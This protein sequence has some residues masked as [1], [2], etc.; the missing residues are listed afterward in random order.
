MDFIKPANIKNNLLIVALLFLITLPASFP[1]F[2]P[3]FFVTQD[4][5]YLPRIYQLDKVLKEGVF[6]VRW[7]P[8][9]RYG[10]PTFNFYAPLPYYFASLLKSIFWFFG[11]IEIIKVLIFLILL[12]SV[13]SMYYFAAEFFK[14]VYAGILASVLYLYAPYHSLD[15]YVRG[16]ISEAFALIFFPLMFLFSLRL[17]QNTNILNLVLLSLSLAGLFL[18]HNVMTLIF[19]PFYIAWIMFLFAISRN[20]KSLFLSLASIIWA[21]GLAAFFLLP[22]FLEKNFVQTEYLTG[23]YFDF[24][25]HFIELRQLFVLFWGYGASLW[26]GEDGLSFQIGLVHWLLASTAGFF[27]LLTFLRN[28]I[29]LK[30]FNSLKLSKEQNKSTS[31]LIFLGLL[32]LTSLFL[33]HNKTAFLWENIQLL[34]F[35]QFP[36]RFLGISIFLISIIGAGFTVYLSNLFSN[37]FQ[38]KGLFI[39]VMIVVFTVVFNTVFFNPQKIDPNTT[40]NDF[41]SQDA[42]LKEENLPKDYLPV[43]V[44]DMHIEKFYSPHLTDGH[45]QLS[46]YKNS[47]IISTLKVS[48]PSF[49]TIEMPIYYFPGWQVYVNN[50]KQE[51]LN[52][53]DFG[54][55]RFNVG[56]GISDV[57]VVFEDTLVRM[58]SNWISAISLGL[59]LI[60]LVIRKNI[61]HLR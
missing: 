41:I 12:L 54:F 39:T 31:G 43:W 14:N 47:S 46:E 48:S 25:G 24:R 59:M 5:V 32:F 40:E 10:E 34:Q 3:G 35:V 11:Y 52:P 36:W 22:A 45:G 19:M 8:D 33:M 4:I 30:I 15:I 50:Q 53:N 60:L 26:G 55:I 23:G 58:L 44:K 16:A 20:L 56:S 13:I 7:S 21:F 61:K 42:L 37:Q 9:L 18:T 2:K 57:K 29:N 28:N 6:P 17:Y 51:I 1:L 49:A 27:V 38:K